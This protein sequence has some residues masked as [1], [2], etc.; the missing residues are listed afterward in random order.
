MEASAGKRSG[1]SAKG[2][3]RQTGVTRRSSKNR[4]AQKRTKASEAMPRP[5]SSFAMFSRALLL[6]LANNVLQDAAMTH[7]CAFHGSVHAHQR[8][9]TD[10]FPVRTNSTNAHMRGLRQAIRKIDRVN[11]N[12]FGAIQAQRC[13][14]LPLFE[15]QRHN[16]HANKVRTMNALETLRNH[17]AHT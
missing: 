8:R 14:I 11:T 12:A 15:L 4:N 3:S 13:A 7:V 2:R 1:R 17:G 9:E 6:Q 10:F 5:P 16:A